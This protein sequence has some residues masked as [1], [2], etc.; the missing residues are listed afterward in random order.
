MLPERNIE[1]Y[2]PTADLQ[3]LVECGFLENNNLAHKIECDRDTV[4]EIISNENL[5]ERLEHIVCKPEIR[6]E[7]LRKS[8]RR[9]FD[10]VNK[11]ENKLLEDE[12]LL[13][14][15]GTVGFVER[16]YSVSSALKSQAIREWFKLDNS[17]LIDYVVDGIEYDGRNLQLRPTS[18]M[19]LSLLEPDSKVFKLKPSEFIILTSNMDSFNYG[20]TVSEIED[21][22][23]IVQLVV[24]AIDEL[25]GQN[26]W[27]TTAKYLEKLFE[28]TNLDRFSRDDLE[29][30]AY[31]AIKKSGYQFVE[32][33]PS[34]HIRARKIAMSTLRKDKSFR[35]RVEQYLEIKGKKKEKGNIERTEFHIKE[36]PS[37]PTSHLRNTHGFE[38]EYPE[39]AVDRENVIR[40]FLS[41][42]NIRSGGGGTGSLGENDP[43]RTVFNEYS[44]GIFRD[45]KTAR[46]LL[47]R[48][49]NSGMIN[50]DTTDLLGLHL[51][52]GYIN[53]EG[54]IEFF[55]SIQATAW[56][57][58][59][60]DK[61]AQ[62]LLEDQMVGTTSC[63]TSRL[64]EK[65]SKI[66]G[67]KI[68][69]IKEFSVQD[70]Q[71]TGLGIETAINI[72]HAHINYQKVLDQYS[73]IYSVDS[74]K[75]PILSPTIVLADSEIE[76]VG[77]LTQYEI[78]LAKEYAS[79][80][81]TIQSGFV[82][83]GNES[84][85]YTTVRNQTIKNFAK[86]ISKVY[87]NFWDKEWVKAEEVR[88]KV[89]RV[90]G[91]EY[92][93]IVH[94]CQQ[95]ALGL[96]T[97]VQDIL[98]EAEDIFFIKLKAITELEN[99]GA[100]ISNNLIEFFEEYPCG[101]KPYLEYTRQKRFLEIKKKY[102][103]SG[104]AEETKKPTCR[105]RR[106][107]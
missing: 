82:A 3:A 5:R 81:R 51:D 61:D 71:S 83:S 57:S 98:Q 54:R 52:L 13:R 11:E 95:T 36:D 100:N 31:L 20:F 106:P 68:L 40:K 62:A 21:N 10:I 92:S 93:N 59:F 15:C 107:L 7:L 26:N 34:E 86:Q 19:E 63:H 73:K 72:S 6:K 58:H 48:L 35:E 39:N 45:G 28:L 87:P 37:G 102:L 85:L 74:N 77:G 55:R 66:D 27:D 90:D 89:F 105:L 24:E 47:K 1:R 42:I 70:I 25:D 16:T 4:N 12:D 30:T 38:I 91:Q 44:P 17:K 46:D 65:R 56:L 8:A 33:N 84:V 9:F 64:Q 2:N 79:Y 96:S 80:I 88:S 99:T 53:K 67:A 75:T 49:A 32:S 97:R 78:L 69:D 50:Y 41:F 29:E 103:K 18:L 101:E 94:F 43:G 104:A 14:L 60:S 76:S 22:Y 23:D